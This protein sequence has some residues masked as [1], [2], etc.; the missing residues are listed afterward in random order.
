MFR[1]FTIFRKEI[2]QI[3]R[4]R[5]LVGIMIVA[6]VLQ[7]L[8][9][10]Y[11]ATFE[12]KNVRIA[13]LDEDRS[14]LTRTI[15]DA[16]NSSETFDIALY[17]EN[18]KQIDEVLKKGKADVVVIF[19]NGFEKSI[20][21]SEKFELPIIID[22]TNSNSA[23]IAMGFMSSVIMDKFISIVENKLSNFGIKFIPLCEPEVRIWFNPEIRSTSFMVPGL[24]G[25][26]L[27]TVTLI[28]TS[29]TMVR[30]KEQGTVELLLVTPIKTYELLLGK[31]LPFILI[32]LFDAI[33]VILVGKFWFRVPLRG[34]VFLL[35][36]S[37]FVFLL[38]TLGLGIFSSVISKTQQQA[39][40]TAYFFAM[41]NIVLSGFVFP[42]ESMPPVIKFITNFIPLKYFLI[43]LRGIF[44]RG[45]GIE[46]LY[47]QI[48]I[49]LGFGVFIFS[50]SVFKFRKYLG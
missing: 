38:T 14:K 22:G 2:S 43:I 19:K 12:V 48:L 26:I 28:M 7:L 21:K 41:P 44:L 32:G 42:V 37:T 18:L 33:A 30:E 8:I 6:P 25:M 31:I 49:L 13:I 29:M 39:L 9:L 1:I 20:I 24:I 46:V 27:I 50:F 10:G 23:T 4:N 3:R 16:L 15:E 36:V 47:P 40:M 34:D 11:A 35:F 17:L 45:A 5:L